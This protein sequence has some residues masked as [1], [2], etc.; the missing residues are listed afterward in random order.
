[1]S[2][3]E[4]WSPIR[5]LWKR[6]PSVAIASLAPDGSP[7]VTPIGSVW[8]HPTE[9]RGIYLE[10]FTSQL[11]K[12]LDRD[13]RF[14]LMLVDNGAWFWLRSLFAGR[15]SRPVAARLHGTAGKRRESTEEERA[16]FQKLVAPVAWTKGHGMLWSSLPFARDLTF[17]RVSGVRLGA[18]TKALSL[19]LHAPR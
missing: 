17:T 12:N 15:F 16:R 18:M 9:P 1:M 10:L 14:A 2:L 5:A 6:S 4:N 3:Q 8:L 13:P 19:P 7:H 11:P